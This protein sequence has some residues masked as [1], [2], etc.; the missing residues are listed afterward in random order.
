MD[1]GESAS[2]FLK[3][4]KTL[5]AFFEKRFFLPGLILIFILS[6][7]LVFVSA[8]KIRSLSSRNNFSLRPV[9]E[10]S[11]YN[12]SA[13]IS[14]VKNFLGDSP[15]MG[16]IQDNTIVGVSS[17]VMITPQ[18]LGSLLDSEGTGTRSEIIKY[19]VKP[20]DT[21]SFIAAKFNISLQTI[22]W[23]NGLNSRSTIKPGQEL[24]I[25]PVSGVLYTVRKNDTLGAIAKR[26]KADVKKIIAFNGLSEEADIYI[27]DPLIIPGGKMP[28]RISRLALIPVAESYFIFP[29]QGI[30]SQ[31][32]HYYNAIDIANKCGKPVVAVS[33]GTVQR[34][35]RIR[36]GGKRITILHPNG[37]VTYYGHLSKILVAPGQKVNTGDIIG[38]IGNT[39]YTLG[40]TGCHLHFEVI[41]AKN[42][43]AKYPVGSYISWKK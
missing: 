23:A 39:G 8:K 17:P 20:G 9:A 16:F 37:V 30:I 3:I 18:V 41:G 14:S 1:D 24:V 10:R 43:L 22:L 7:S 31:G 34:V 25:L 35:G 2:R 42:F 6:G 32:L 21:L 11:F 26:Y 38:Y 5:K 4:N 33:D 29:C 40:P 15:E 19:S 13:F 12:K 28:A 27:G 36:V